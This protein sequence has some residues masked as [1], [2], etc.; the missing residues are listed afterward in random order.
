MNVARN[1]SFLE[2]KGQIRS[3]ATNGRKRPTGTKAA[4]PEAVSART[5]RPLPVLANKS[6]IDGIQWLSF[7]LVA[8]AIACVEYADYLVKSMS[9]SYLY[10]LPLVVAAILLL[11]SITF[12]LPLMCVLL[13]DVIVNSDTAHPII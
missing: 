10:I 8:G 5:H 12:T 6:S 11:R 7:A 9:L 4:P 3:V 1:T 13:H 2:N